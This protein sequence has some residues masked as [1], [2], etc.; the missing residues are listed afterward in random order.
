MKYPV[1]LLAV[2]LLLLLVAT[3]ALAQARLVFTDETGNLNQSRIEQAARPLLNRGAEVAIYMVRQGSD[4]DFAR[5][6]EA[7]GFI[8]GNSARARMIAIYVGLDNRMSSIRYG[9]AWN[10]AL[11]TNNN[12]DAIRNNRLNAALAQQEYTRAYVDTLGAIEQAIVSP[13]RPGGGTIFNFDFIP[14]VIGVFVLIGLFVVGGTVNRRR[15][16]A[17]ALAA[18][19]QRFT[20]AQQA[21]AGAITDLAQRLK[22]A[23]EKARFD[24]VSYA[25]ADVERLA[26]AQ[27][28][29]RQRFTNAKLRF[30]DVGENL[31]RH[32]NPNIAQYDEAA[33]GYAQV[34]ELA[35]NLRTQLD[36]IDATRIELDRLAQQAPGEID[37]AK[38]A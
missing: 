13:P 26:K 34:Q 22:T 29:V 8:S 14:V 2:V 30:D 16:A 32:A 5:R 17:R 19:R 12:V 3:P 33:Q 25:P 10:E 21:A 27:D 24:R 23:D 4:A 15:A 1:R 11:R 31:N 9:D 37:R 38:K 7:D 28:E 18:A 20:E 35:A 6:L 36:E